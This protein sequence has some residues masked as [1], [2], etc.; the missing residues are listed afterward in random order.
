MLYYQDNYIFSVQWWLHYILNGSD[1]SNE[2]RR[3]S[4]FG[5]YALSARLSIVITKDN[6]L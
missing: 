5:S 1:H 4:E 2:F 6:M 3:E